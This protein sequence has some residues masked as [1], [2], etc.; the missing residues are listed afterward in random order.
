MSILD[1]RFSPYNRPLSTVFGAPEKM[2]AQMFDEDADPLMDELR[3]LDYRYV[4]LVYHPLKDKF[5]V[6]SGWKDP[7][8]KHVRA[9]CAGIDADEKEHR[10]T[11]FGT[12]MID[13]DQKSIPQLLVDEVFHPFYVF[14]IA[15]L[16][17][18]SLDEYYYY[19][20]CIFVMSA[21][22][23]I[24]TLVETRAV[25]DLVFSLGVGGIFVTDTLADDETAPRYI[26]VR[27]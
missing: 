16:V 17:L 3:A 22:S 7:S 8:W 23:I 6:S 25:S 26:A 15:S 14:Q 19:A 27:V 2:F 20:I 11:V 9:L 24:A 1:I 13:I 18:W 5:I 10:E 21:A 12:N 4:R